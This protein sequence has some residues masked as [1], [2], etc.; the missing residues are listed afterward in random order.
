MEECLLEGLSDLTIATNLLEARLVCGNNALYQQLIK[1]IFSQGFWPS[2]DF[3]AAKIDEQEQ[4]HQR[5]HSTSYNLEPDIKS[6][7]GDFVIFTPLYG[8]LTVILAQH[9]YLKW[10]T[11]AF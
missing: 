3:F 1:H 4:R 8:S 6:S 2:P 11:L 5:F 9:Q 10:S 7:P